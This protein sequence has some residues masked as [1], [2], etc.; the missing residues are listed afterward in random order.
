MKLFFAIIIFHLPY[1]FAFN[2]KKGVWPADSFNFDTIFI[3]ACQ[4]IPGIGFS[5]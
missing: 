5:S 2:Q 3:T 4:E 1:L